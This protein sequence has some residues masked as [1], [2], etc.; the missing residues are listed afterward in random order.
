MDTLADC[1]M[2]LKK[3]T[4]EN[5]WR[6]KAA[7]SHIRV[8]GR[9][10]SETLIAITNLGVCLFNQG[11]S[12]ESLPLPV[13]TKQ[14]L[15]NGISERLHESLALK[16]TPFFNG[17]FH[18]SSIFLQR[19]LGAWCLPLLL[20]TLGAWRLAVETF[21]FQDSPHGFNIAQTSYVTT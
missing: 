6:Q 10:G 8:N 4:D 15:M 21:R 20:S 1:L 3:Y 11:R 19:T 5:E 2:Q 9:L 18:P 12:K 16:L 7:D 17:L 13:G 14:L